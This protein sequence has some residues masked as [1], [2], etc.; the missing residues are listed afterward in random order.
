LIIRFEKSRGDNILRPGDGLPISPAGIFK[1]F[2]GVRD[3]QRTAGY[4]QTHCQADNNRWTNHTNYLGKPEKEKVHYSP[5]K[6]WQEGV[7][8][9]SATLAKPEL[10]SVAKIPLLFWFDWAGKLKFF[11]QHTISD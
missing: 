2:H 5:K 4:Q 11:H 8:Q 7:K 9:T 6:G 10:G 1:I 3:L